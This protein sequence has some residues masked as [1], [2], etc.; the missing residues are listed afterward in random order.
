MRNS[1]RANRILPV[2]PPPHS[3]PHLPR[4]SAPGAGRGGHRNRQDHRLY[5]PCQ[6]LGG[7]ESGN[8]LD[9][10]LHAAPATPDRGGTRPACFPDPANG[11][12]RR[13]AQR[14]RKLSLPAQSSGH[15]AYRTG[16]R[17]FRTCHWAGADRSLGHGDPGRRHPGRRSA[18][19]DRRVV[20]PSPDRRGCGPARGVHP[21]RLPPLA[22][23]LRGA[24]HPK[25]ASGRAGHR[26]PC[27]R[28]D[29]G[30]AWLAFGGGVEE[31]GG[32][33][34]LCFRRGP[35]LV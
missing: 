22:D 23:V 21:R 27:A 33:Q 5:C 10:H 2:L 15:G 13:H 32:S 34:P 11:A 8:C 25:G 14:P 9:Q 24:Q 17:G 29:P 30:R 20:R 3:P 26:Q 35:S 1:G 31:F 6:P 4:R 19:V 7:K 28:D 18:R 12:P 16:G